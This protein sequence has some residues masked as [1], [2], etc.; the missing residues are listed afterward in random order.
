MNLIISSTKNDI[1]GLNG[2]MLWNNRSDIERYK[3]ITLGGILIMGNTTYESLINK[4]LR[5]HY[6]IVLT[7]NKNLKE[8]IY[9]EISGETN[10]IFVNS[11]EQAL[12]V[13]EEIQQKIFEAKE[14]R[15]EIF[16]IGGSKIFEQFEPYYT[17]IYHT[18]VN[19][20]YCD[21]QNYTKYT[22]NLEG[23]KLIKNERLE[24]SNTTC[25]T[26]FRIYEKN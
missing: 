2:K 8:K 20:F 3:K 5:Y 21:K 6:N 22:I 10:V 14:I 4:R 13:C 11:V 25:K 9:K 26:E 18:I 24:E 17:K 23:F 19:K 7:T 15:K 12:E 16:V 1:I